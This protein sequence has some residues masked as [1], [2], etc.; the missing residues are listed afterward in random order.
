MIVNDVD[1]IEDFHDI[2]AVAVF[3]MRAYIGV[4]I[5][6]ADGS[7]YGTLCALDRSP[8]Q[9]G[10]RDIDMLVILARLLASQ[11]DRQATGAL[12]ER[13]RIAREIHDTLAQT[14]AALVLDMSLHTIHLE[15]VA[16]ELVNNAQ[17]MEDATRDALQEVRR[18][19]WNLQPGALEGKSLSDA[20][21]IELR[22]LLR[23]G[24]DASIELRGPSGPLP[25]PI[26]TAFIRI[27]QE[28]LANV[29]K[30]SHASQVIVTLEYEPDLVLLRIDDNGR[31]IDLD[32]LA[33][34]TPTGG[35]GL[36]TMRERARL[37]GGELQIW[38]RPGGGAS[39][40]CR[41]PRQSG[42]PPIAPL[43]SGRSQTPVTQSLVRVGIVDDHSIV[44]EGLQRLIGSASGIEVIWDA[45]DAET[46]LK[47]V[48]RDSPDVLLLD[49]QM[50]GIG[51][52]GCLEQLS[53]VSAR[54]RV[55]V[56]TTFA[57]DEMVF[58]AMRLGAR[59]YL[60]KDATADTLLETI[61][62][63][64]AGGTRITPVAAERLAARVQQYE[65]LTPREREVLELLASGLR[66]KEIAAQLGTSE[67]TVQFHVANLY[68]KLGVSSRAEATRAALE[69]GLVASPAH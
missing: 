57:Q 18:S 9:K 65:A 32:N 27:A 62:S 12:E 14:L 53:N 66:N 29:R 15:Q 64:A 7:L 25:P 49:L 68:G 40:L 45:P 4:P 13:Q 47:L 41:I 35:Y 10:R 69:R 24:I 17:R 31:G 48:E 58:Q 11:I 16:P 36:T 44:R 33:P 1:E 21:A 50:P 34:A 3:R 56:L 67:K 8:Q 30:H 37:A 55:I 5:V 59:G 52:L 46:G 19:I 61:R 63:V 22:G 60:L 26:E 54:S 20:I 6:L 43:P 42:G 39:L 38:T 23:A 2:P 28:A 51:G